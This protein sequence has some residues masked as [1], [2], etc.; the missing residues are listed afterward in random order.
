M[1]PFRIIP[2]RA[3]LLLIDLQEKMLQAVANREKVTRNAGI[4]LEAAKVM[5]VPIKF[6]EHYPGGL[7][8]TVPP[9]MEKMPSGTSPFEKIHFSCLDEK[10]FEEFLREGGRDQLIVAGVESHICVLATVMDLLEKGHPVAVA[11][12]ACSSRDPDHHRMACE[13]M[14]AAG[15]LVAPVETLAYQVIR[16]AGT[17]QF[18]AMLPFFKA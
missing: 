4:L 3:Q 9:L 14:T 18:K 1:L 15:A 5:G 7:G 2:E 13:A 12:D 16:R 8:K 11:A 10:G 17:E 6:T